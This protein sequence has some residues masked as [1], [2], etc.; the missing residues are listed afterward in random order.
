M[1]DRI[2]EMHEHHMFK[3]R[4]PH[5]E[6]GLLKIPFQAKETAS[7][8][9]QKTRP[10][11]IL[12]SSDIIRIAGESANQ[13]L[14]VWGTWWCHPPLASY[15]SRLVLVA[16]SGRWRFTVSSTRLREGHDAG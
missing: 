12:P 16:A 14:I 10:T 15:I 1:G 4:S 2:D 6:L 13:K 9:L 11:I 7:S 5:S 3:M 8:D